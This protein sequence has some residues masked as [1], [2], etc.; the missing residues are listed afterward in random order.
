[1][2]VASVQHA[3]RLLQ[4]AT[5]ELLAG[6]GLLGLDGPM[7]KLNVCLHGGIVAGAKRQPAR[8]DVEVGIRR[9]EAMT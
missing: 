2:Q 5:R 3:V 8:V 6:H 4:I 9:Q 1:V 7:E